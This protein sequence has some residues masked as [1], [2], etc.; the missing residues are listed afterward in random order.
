MIDQLASCAR[1]ACGRA[2]QPRRANQRYC[3]TVCTQEAGDDQAYSLNPVMYPPG[4]PTAQK[5]CAVCGRMFVT[6]FRNQ[7]ACSLACAE[8]AE[9]GV[10][11]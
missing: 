8:R 10:D 4:A 3:S 7:E 6:R 5:W 1:P 11:R 9:G 2:Y